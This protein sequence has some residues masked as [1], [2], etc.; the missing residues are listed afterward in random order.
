MVDIE[1]DYGVESLFEDDYKDAQAYYKRALQFRDEG[2]AFSLVFNIASVALERYLV[3][4]CEL[5][6]VEPM[7][8]NFIT[9]MI[10]VDKLIAVPKSLS[11]E[12]KTL[13]QIF[14]ICFLDTYYHGIP[15]GEDAKRT[16]R[17]CEDV[18]KLFD[19]QKITLVR[20]ALKCLNDAQDNI[21]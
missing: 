7:N 4:L 17:M 3:A 18:E 19:Q 20:D 13:D 2:H 8:H 1:Y 11:K 16:L 12:I 14:G 6:G 5:H 9:L 15:T 10:T 21:T